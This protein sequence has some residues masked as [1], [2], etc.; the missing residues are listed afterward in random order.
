MFYSWTSEHE[1]HVFMSF[2]ILPS[3]GADMDSD[4]Q[5]FFNPISLES[6]N[7][8]KDINSILN[9]ISVLY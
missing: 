4:E 7:S 3:Y 6:S 8:G 2:Q 9:D 1:R 5:F